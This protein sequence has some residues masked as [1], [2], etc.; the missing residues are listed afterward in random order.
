MDWSNYNELLIWSSFAFCLILTAGGIH[1]I[2]R[3]DKGDRQ[4]ASRY[5]Q[6]FLI[7]L[8][9]FGYYCLWSK[10]LIL[11]FLDI[12][13]LVH[14]TT[15][16]AQMGVPFFLISLAMQLVWASKLQGSSMKPL[17]PICLGLG[18]VIAIALWRW[19][20]TDPVQAAYSLAAFTVSILVLY[21]F[22]SG[23]KP[24]VSNRWG[25]LLLLLIFAAGLIH[26]SYFSSILQFEYYDTGFVLLFFLCNTAMVVVY[27]HSRVPE[28]A[29]LTFGDFATKYSITKREGDIIQ[30]IYAGKTNKEIADK[31]F[32]TVQTVKDHSSRIYQKTFVKNRAQLATLLRDYGSTGSNRDQS[33]SQRAEEPA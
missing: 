9:V 17:L 16:V 23:K 20:V 27:I 26:L 19:Q 28:S 8:Y 14:L 30:G 18:A 25:N 29:Q 12:E 4:Q 11:Q 6:Y 32:I 7:F 15:I 1:A 13:N 22:A 2:F 21:I 3:S 5:L 24:I 31:L 33:K 10:I